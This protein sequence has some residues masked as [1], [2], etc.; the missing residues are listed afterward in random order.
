MTNEERCCKTL[1]ESINELYLGRTIQIYCGDTN[2][3]MRYS[4]EDKEKKVFFEG[5]VLWGRGNVLAIECSFSVKDEVHGIVKD[6]K[7]DILINDWS[8][9]CTMLKEDDVLDLSY[10]IYKEKR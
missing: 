7:R 1:A 2:S 8:I 3:V 9:T 4:E 6:V 5:K 10:V